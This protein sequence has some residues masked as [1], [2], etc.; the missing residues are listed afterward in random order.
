MVKPLV[1]LSVKVVESLPVIRARAKDAIA[2]VLT[3][4][5]RRAERPLTDRFRQTISEAIKQS[6]T[7]NS[8]VNSDS[9]DS[10][11]AQFGLLNAEAK[12]EQIINTWMNNIKVTVKPI[13]RTGSQFRGGITIRAIK[14]DY[15]DV[16]ALPAA[17]QTNTGPKGG[18]LDWLHWL[19]I[20][21]D[22]IIVANYKVSIPKG[23]RQK[24]RTGIAVMVKVVGEQWSVPSEHAGTMDRNFVTKAL[25]KLGLDKIVE[26]EIKRSLR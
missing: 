24:S 2:L 9:L 4:K 5:F 15:A 26:Q 21:G 20:R 6:A 8:L 12:M 11:H 16:L 23:R 3:S 1:L 10:L 25:N 7:Y 18:D 19:L 22:E 17:T 14:S 13:K